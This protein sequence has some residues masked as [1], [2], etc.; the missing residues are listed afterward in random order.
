[1]SLKALFDKINSYLGLDNDEA[2]LIIALRI[3]LLVPCVAIP[4]LF[5]S[6][7]FPG[8]IFPKIILSKT[9][10]LFITLMM[11]IYYVMNNLDDLIANHIHVYVF[12]MIL[13]TLTVVLRSWNYDWK[14]FFGTS[15]KWLIGMIFLLATIGKFLAP[16]F[17]DGSFFEFIAFNDK[18][19]E[20]FTSVLLGA[21]SEMLS[22]NKQVLDTLL[23]T[24]EPENSV[25]YFK[26]TSLISTISLY[27]TYWTV[28]I[29][30]LI[31]LLFLLPERVKLSKYRD[32]VLV[33][34]IITTYPIATVPGFAMS[35]LLLA[36]VQSYLKNDRNSAYTLL[37]LFI[38]IFISVFAFPYSPYIK[39]FF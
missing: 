13:G 1:M 4:H 18:R 7:F 31:A 28:V 5:I 11:F 25:Y 23:A 3:I 22:E 21:Q 36:F 6:L 34:F 2:F 35:L 39:R 17:A 29:E 19:F 15:A 26:S 33:L 30:G 20:G 14:L 24:K 38:F 32:I 8:I 10:W 16:E 27:M 12:L 9:Y 37:Y